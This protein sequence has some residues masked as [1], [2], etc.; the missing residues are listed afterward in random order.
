MGEARLKSRT[1]A[2]ILAGEPRCIYCNAIPNQLEHMPPKSM[3]KGRGR[4][5]GM[6]FAACQNCN[7]GTSAADLVASFVARI[8]PDI[9]DKAWRI[10]EAKERR[11]K[12]EQIAPGFLNEF[13]RPDTSRSILLRKQGL[14]VPYV[15]MKADGPLLKGYL[16]TF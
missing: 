12:L 5:H 3:F 14:L 8:S 10:I 7:N 1:R 11:G 4:P 16:T 9:D 15:R 2:E 13:F 6:E